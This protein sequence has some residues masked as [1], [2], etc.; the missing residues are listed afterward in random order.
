MMIMDVESTNVKRLL[1][2]ITPPRRS[3]AR[4]R[5][6]LATGLGASTLATSAVDAEIVVLD[7][8]AGGFRNIE[9]F[10]T[11]IYFHCGGLRLYP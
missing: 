11:V 8:G 9:N 3:A 4:L 7:V 6:Y 2:H 10:K 5:G 1:R